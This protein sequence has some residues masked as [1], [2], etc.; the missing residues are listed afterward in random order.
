FL[1][2]VLVVGCNS[3]VSTVG[4]T[5]S[6]A[7][8][9]VASHICDNGMGCRGV[10]IE[11]STEGDTTTCTG[12]FNDPPTE[13]DRMECYDGLST[14]LVNAFAEADAAGIAREDIDACV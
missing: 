9:E 6:E 12:T 3:G 7:A 8:E 1:S 14:G 13:A 5:P 4:K 10:S 11:C 2:L